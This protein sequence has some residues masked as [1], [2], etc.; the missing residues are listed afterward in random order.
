MAVNRKKGLG[1]GLDALI[2][3]APET[4]EEPKK[5]EKKE[6]AKVESENTTLAGD[7]VKMVNL[8][9]IEPD[10]NQPRSTFNDES[11]SQLADSIKKNGL[12]EPILV[13][14]KG[15][16]F[17][18]IAG[19]RRWRASRKAGLKEIPVIVKDLSEEQIA[20]IQI[21]ENMQRED[22]NPIEEALAYK[23]L[24]TEFNMTQEQIAEEVSKSRTA[25][26]NSLRLL[27]LTDGVQQMIID[28]KLTTGHARA[29]I[30][31]DDEE[32]QQEIADRI[33]S[34]KLSV[35]DV[36]KL[37][38]A[39]STKKN[40]IVAVRNQP[41]EQLDI[42]YTDIEEKLKDKLGTKVAI[43]GKGNGQGVISIEFYSHADLD[44]IIEQIYK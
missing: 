8:S 34:E 15:D 36:E 4:I 6:P 28:G 1:R 27:K 24:L 33:V 16:Y 12:L 42:I 32:K 3:S 17:R 13:Q 40:K 37:M 38:K 20:V 30:T 11:L 29:L 2:P 25:V 7:V 19:E 41:D 31:I 10:R 35:R 5:V 18:I 23:R 39:N 9:K 21:I 26:T 22:I 44:K 43:S 14:D